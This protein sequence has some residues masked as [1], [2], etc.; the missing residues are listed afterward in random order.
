M[1]AAEWAPSQSSHDKESP[2]MARVWWDGGVR[3]VSVVLGILFWL[4]GNSV[5][6]KKKKNFPGK[7][8]QHRAACKR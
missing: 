4:G 3:I 5:V 6:P 1:Q 2:E 7:L 8:H